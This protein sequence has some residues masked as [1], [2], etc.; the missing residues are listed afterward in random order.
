MNYFRAALTAVNAM[1][2]VTAL[3]T[4]TALAQT[5]VALPASTV[6]A[7]APHGLGTLILTPSQRRDLEALRHAAGRVN[8]P[9][10][11]SAHGA[12]GPASATGRGLE[13]AALP[14]APAI[15]GVVVRSGQRSTVWVN[16]QP[17]YGHAAADPS[18]VLAGQA[19]DSLPPGS[20]RIIPPKAG[21]TANKE[22]LN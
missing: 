8:D 13:A 11:V 7:T 18:R 22:Q 6:Q 15:N 16:G 3:S 1:T 12:V 17:Q 10:P 9:S 5:G 4:C 2:T 21:V 14:G 20:I 19:G